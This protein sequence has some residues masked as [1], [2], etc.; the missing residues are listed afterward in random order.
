MLNKISFKKIKSPLSLREAKQRSNLGGFSLIELMVAI[1]IL[2]IAIFGIFHAYSVGFM[3]M[4]D[5]RDRTV[6]TNYAQEAMEDIKNKDFA[7]I[8]TQSRNYIDGTKYERE[9]IVQSSINLKEVTTK[10]YWEDRN[11]NLKIVKTDM[12]VHFIE[13]TAGI[14]TRIMLIAEPYNILTED[15]T[16]TDIIE[17]R[18]IINAIVKDKDGSTVIAYNGNV[19]FTLHNINLGILIDSFGDEYPNTYSVNA[20]EGIAHVTFEASGTE[21]DAIIEASNGPLTPDSVTITVTNIDK[22][23]KINLTA[24]KMFMAATDISTSEITATIVNAGGVLVEIPQEITFSVSGPGNLSTPTTLNTVDENGAPTGFATITLT[25]NG[26]GGTITVTASAGGLTPG[27]I[28]IITGGIISLSIPSLN[29]PVN[30]TSIITVST[31]DVDGVPINYNGKIN[32]SVN[33]DTSGILSLS[34]ID[35]SETDNSSETVTFTAQGA[36]GTV[37]DITAVDEKG[38]LILEHPLTLNIT[39][40]L[41]PDYIEVYAIPS[42]IPAG[43][44]ITSL[45]TARVMTDAN[46]IVTSY[47]GYVEFNTNVASLDVIDAKFTNG[48]ATAV[49]NPS[50]EPGTATIK[51]YSPSESNFTISGETTVGFYIGAD[52]IKLEAIPGSILAGNKFCTVTAWVLDNNNNLISNYNEDISFV[53]SPWPYTINFSKATTYILTQKVKK[54]VTTV[55]LKSGDTPG[56]AVIEAYSGDISGSLNIPVVIILELAVPEYISYNSDYVSFDI[57]VQGVD[58]VLEKMRVSWVPNNSEVLKKIEINGDTVYL[59]DVG[60][61][62]ETLVDINDNTILPTETSNV[63]MYFNNSMSGKTFTVI[64]NSNSVNYSVPITEPEMP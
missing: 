40:E 3:G 8:I 21:G 10:V 34:S 4:A 55:I 62:N 15:Y 39:A 60:V 45:I 31:K 22:A 42:S 43:G 1:A 29:V 47:N 59:N 30:E 38:I 7:Q 63:K 57:D 24:T 41:I 11:N 50:S 2:A 37:V 17:N 48:I 49:L 6:A 32:L 20:V 33:P 25:S 5:A 16:S 18:T 27:V 13:T 19:T 9:V 28:D 35:F 58:L 54:G 61:P 12:V 44:T 14:P 46:N 52:Y 64:F 51:V 26:I 23:V 53:I 36:S 56:T